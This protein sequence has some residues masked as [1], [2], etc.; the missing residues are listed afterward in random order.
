MTEMTKEKL[1]GMRKYF[2]EYAVG[3]LVSAVIFLFTL[4]VKMN[5]YVNR[6]LMEQNTKL[7]IAIERNTA[8][9]NSLKLNSR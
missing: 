3:V 8:A 6:E 4:Y 7:I 9:I 2:F 1:S 5:D